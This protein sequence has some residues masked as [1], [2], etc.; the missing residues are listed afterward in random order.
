M[1]R[2]SN[3]HRPR[4]AWIRLGCALTCE[5]L[6]CL[7]EITVAYHFIYSLRCDSLQDSPIRPSSY[8]FG[9]H[10]VSRVASTNALLWLGL[11]VLFIPQVP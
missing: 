10:A 5:A 2:H 8:H 3:Q 9:V 11:T 7:V 6:S 1:I 4:D